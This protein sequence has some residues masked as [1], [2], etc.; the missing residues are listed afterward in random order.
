MIAPFPVDLALK[1]GELPTVVPVILTCVFFMIYWFISQSGRIRSF[2]YRRWDHDTAAVRHFLFSKILGLLILG[3]IPLILILILLPEYHMDDLGLTP[4]VKNTLF[5]GIAAAGLVLLAGLSAIF[6]ARKARDFDH[7]PQIRA[8]QWTGGTII[9]TVAGWALYL[10]GYELLFRG[11]LLM[12]LADHLGIWPAI[13]VNIALYS[14][15]HIPQGPAEAFGAAPVGLI[16]CLVTLASG[17]IWIAF[18]IHLTMA[19][20]NCLT[21]MK[22]NPEITY[23][24]KTG[25]GTID[26]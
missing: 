15:A 21:S 11:I 5:A 9:L 25:P 17:T 23:S 2:F 6:A 19:T 4:R 8:R 10:L 3:M 12:P 1:E 14:A 24:G 16:L 22:I 20:A 26:L 18:L 7:F 13:A